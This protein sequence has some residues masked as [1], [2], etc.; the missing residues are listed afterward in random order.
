VIE[1]PISAPPPWLWAAFTFVAA[2][3]QAL[4]NAAQH[5]L[6]P[7]IGA[8]N[9]AFVRFLFGLPFALVFLPLACV[10]AG[11]APAFPSGAALL[12][13]V[14]ASGA[15][16]LATALMLLAMRT[17]SFVVATAL[18]KTEAVQI[19]GFGLL[20]LGDPVTPELLLAVG[21]ATAGVSILSV[22]S[23]EALSHADRRSKHRAAAF[24][25]ASAAFFGLATVG[26]RESLLAQ[27]NANFVVGASMASTLALALQSATILTWLAF[28]DRAGARAILAEARGS[29]GAGFL[30]AFATLFWF[31]ALALQT[32]ARVRTLGLVEAL[33]AAMLSHHL[34]AQRISR[35]ETFGVALILAGVELAL[36]GR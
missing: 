13:L 5:D 16:V 3:A 12:A 30:G 23:R 7:R 20:F 32:A 29:L 22:P 35:R 27:R 21:L 26:F 1:A 36:N 6:V 33:V 19:L 4:R 17:H 15:Q 34:F 24:G 14:F 11:E 2:G 9:A 25:L 8:A 18:V 10:F 28:A 31:L